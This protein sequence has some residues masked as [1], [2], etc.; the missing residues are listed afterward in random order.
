MNKASHP[1]IDTLLKL[2]GNPRI[3]VFT[4]PL[5]GIPFNLYIPY[6]S[7]YMLALGLNDSQIG[8]ISSVGLFFQIFM[9]LISGPVT[10]KLGRRMTT[11]V[12]DIISWSFPMLI[13]AFAQNF[14]HFFI[15]AMLASVVRITANSWVL[16]LVEDAPKNKLVSI[17]SW[18]TIAAIISGL[19]A[20]LAGLLVAHYSLVTAVRILYINA[21][22]MMS[23]KFILLYVLGTETKQGLVKM[24]Q[25]ASV[26]LWKLFGGNKGALR[27]IVRN[28]YTL[29]TFF[30]SLIILVYDTV[31][32]LFLS[33][34]VV[35]QLAL[36]ESAIALLPFLRSILMLLFY[37]F[38]IPHMNHLKFRRPFLAGFALLLL[39]NI[40]LVCS[41]QASYV[42]VIL[43]TLLDAAGFALITPFKETLVVDAVDPHERAGIMGV[44]NVSM[45]VIAS[46]F[47]FLA[48]IMS[49]YSRYLPFYFLIL[50]ALAGII[51]IFRISTHKTEFSVE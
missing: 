39:S 7:V 30:I 21:F 35:K 34:F 10:D 36:P 43:S 4:E 40:A 14:W 33:V 28:P 32:M 2:Q 24:K 44:F 25:T 45:L 3:C 42:F 19:F 50:L 49:D 5:W 27:A 6:V 13:W 8:L 22:V 47:G 20:P 26:P 12:F 11:F 15:A 37:F 9:S 29:C 1:L 48:G 16:L 46:P 18:I 17:W 51:L 31:K 41:P 38:V 23:A